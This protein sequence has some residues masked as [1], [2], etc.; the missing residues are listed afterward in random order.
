MYKKK[1]RVKPV[2]IGYARVS[3]DDQKLD[4]Q[5]DALAKYGCDVVFKDFGVSGSYMKRAGLQEALEACY[6]SAKDSVSTELVIWKLDRL[7]RDT[8]E[9]LTLIKGLA[10]KNVKLHSITEGLGDYSP[11]TVFMT[12]IS[13]ATAEYERN[14]TAQR[15]NAGIQSARA[16]GVIFGRPKALT[17]DQED[18][19]R[20]AL[21]SHKMPRTALAKAFKISRGTLYNYIKFFNST[22]NI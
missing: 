14:Q 20:E 9:V 8:I 13:A 15:R 6:S 12:A 3:T 22:K 1:G 16:R 19:L 18:M 4:L 17:D 11:L 21:A 7:G 5:L 2:K 10:A